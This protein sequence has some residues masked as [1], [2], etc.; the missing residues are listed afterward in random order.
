MAFYAAL[1]TALLAFVNSLCG[2]GEEPVFYFGDYGSRI[3]YA[4]QPV[5]VALLENEVF[6]RV[7]LPALKLC[8]RRST[9][10]RESF[11]EV[12]RLFTK[13]NLNC[14]GFDDLAWARWC[15]AA[16]ILL[17]EHVHK[18]SSQSR[19]YR[20]V[21]L[22][23]KSGDGKARMDLLIELWS[24]YA[25]VAHEAAH[26][27]KEELQPASSSTSPLAVRQRGN[28]NAR[29]DFENFQGGGCLKACLTGQELPQQEHPDLF[30]EALAAPAPK[31]QLAN[32]D[33][34]VQRPRAKAK[35]RATAKAAATVGAPAEPQAGEEDDA[36][37][38]KPASFLCDYGRVSTIVDKKTDR[39]YI[40]VANSSSRACW[41]TVSSSSA[42][43]TGRTP[44]WVCAAIMKRIQA[45]KLDQVGAV[46]VKQELLE[47]E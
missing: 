2:K 37:I 8:Y 6:L 29:T 23:D 44:L 1:V 35:G 26:L 3:K 10:V 18:L 9:V 40:S 14:S 46:A 32:Q 24:D 12:R 47:E 4:N 36:R 27:V 16:S 41:L 5:L 34:G 20:Q 19:I 42:A 13:K 43:S 38:E 39:A 7:V 22:Q 28:I 45:D 17:A 11:L 33:A 31:R 21:L 25:P 15:A 30:A